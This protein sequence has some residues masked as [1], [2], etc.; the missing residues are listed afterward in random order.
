MPVN[1][2]LEGGD[3]TLARVKPFVRGLFYD[4]DI[5]F[6]GVVNGAFTY[7]NE[8]VSVI[9]YGDNTLTYTNFG[10]QAQGLDGR[11][12]SKN[13]A[14]EDYLAALNFLKVDQTQ[15]NT[16]YLAQVQT[17]GTAHTFCFGLLSGGFPLTWTEDFRRNLN[18]PMQYP[19][20]VTAQFGQVV[21]YK[22]F[23]MNFT[24]DPERPAIQSPVQQAPDALNGNLDTTRPGEGQV[25]SVAPNS[26]AASLNFSWVYV[27]SPEETSEK[28]MG[29]A[30]V[31]D[32]NFE[33]GVTLR[34]WGTDGHQ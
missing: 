30:F 8:L 9:Y 13:A 27:G 4:S 16:Y 21:N 14:S 12:A 32:K 18:V 26:S 24:A 7:S 23:V 31:I 11:R 15:K 29:L 6:S 10:V 22:R 20:E 17:N 19:L 28:K 3:L 5:T 33:D 1:P 2:F 34:D 25:R